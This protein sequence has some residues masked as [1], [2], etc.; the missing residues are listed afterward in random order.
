MQTP[1][2][3][4]LLESICLTASVRGHP[5]TTLEPSGDGGDVPG[6][7]TLPERE[8]C[9]AKSFQLLPCIDS[10]TMPSFEQGG[11]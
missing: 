6:T 5:R 1:T 11:G 4:Q 8:H 9:V 7:Y 3:A 10:E 2:H